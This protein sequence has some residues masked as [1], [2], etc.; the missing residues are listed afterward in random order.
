MTQKKLK[1]C[2]QEILN[3]NWPEYDPNLLEEK[4]YFNS[5]QNIAGG[6]TAGIPFAAFISYKL[7]LPMT[8]IR[9]KSKGFSFSKDDYLQDELEAS[10]IYEETKDQRVQGIHS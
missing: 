2:F 3:E 9:K 4:T 8:Y 5:L 1:D 6:E 7:K 10:F